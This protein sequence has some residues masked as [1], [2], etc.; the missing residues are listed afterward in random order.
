MTNKRDPY[1]DITD[2]IVAAIEAGAPPWVR[3]WRSCAGASDY[4]NALTGRPYHGINTF[5]L[6]MEPYADP[7]WLTFRQAK[8]LGGSVR[9][10]QS[11]T[12]IAFWKFLKVRDRNRDGDGEPERL[13][14][15]PFL[16]IY[17][18]FNVAQ[19]EGVKLKDNT[20]E[21]LTEPERDAALEAFA[22]DSGIPIAEGG[23][24]AY[25]STTLDSITLPPRDDARA[26]AHGPYRPRPHR[27]L[28]HGILRHGGT[29][30]RA[31]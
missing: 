17:S 28:W 7:R 13:K 23:D 31:W 12:R 10:G 1:Q 30:C 27:A 3:P 6:A 29:R 4:R 21:T 11:A 22:R 9:R 19:C 14:T 5:L 25:Y 26:R 24:K 20:A 8:Q 2:R 16:R 15:I 18:V